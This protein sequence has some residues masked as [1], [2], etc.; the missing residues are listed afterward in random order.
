[1]VEIQR[2]DR[3]TYSVS[4]SEQKRGKPTV[5]TGTAARQHDPECQSLPL[6]KPLSRR[7]DAAREQARGRKAE[8]NP[9]REEDLVVLRGEA[10]HADEEGDADGAVDR[11]MVRAVGVYHPAVEE[12]ARP[13]DIKSV[14]AEGA[15]DGGW[16]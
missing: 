9:L 14:R 7:H 10:K 11:D 6:V 5:R 8:P 4:L 12:A 15:G 3:P 1:M 13:P 16:G 2:V